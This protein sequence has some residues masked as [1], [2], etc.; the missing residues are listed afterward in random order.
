MTKLCRFVLSIVLILFTTLLINTQ[1]KGIN[2]DT[3]YLLDDFNSNVSVLNNPWEGFTDQVMGGISKM[4]VIRKSDNDGNY[5]QMSGEVSLENNGGFIQ[6]RQSL[7][8]SFRSFNGASF[9]GIK[10]RARGEGTGYYIFLRTS[11]TILPWQYYSALITLREDWSDIYIPWTTFNKGDYGTIGRL[12]IKK[13]K[14][15]AVVAYGKDFT[16]NIDVS[17]IGFYRI[18]K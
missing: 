7:A 8:S 18:T 11:S 9:D 14:S 6:I 13:L 16:A 10:I 2:M 12:N 3:Y 5:I 15:L 4:R 17:E 1:E